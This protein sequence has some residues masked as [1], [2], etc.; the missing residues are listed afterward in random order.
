MEQ[1]RKWVERVLETGGM[2]GMEELNE[3]FRI[4]LMLDEMLVTECVTN[5]Q[6][7]DQCC[8]LRG[9]RGTETI[10]EPN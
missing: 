9:R 5:T 6:E 10:S 3:G 7:S 2:M 8:R 1:I 4:K